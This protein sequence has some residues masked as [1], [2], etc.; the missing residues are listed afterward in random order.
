MLVNKTATQEFKDEVVAEVCGTIVATMGSDGKVIVCDR[1]DTPHPTKDG[2]TVA[3]AVRFSHPEKDLIASMIAECCIRTDRVCGDGTTTTAFLLRGFYQRFQHLI[4][5]RTK[6]KLNQYAQETLDVLSKLAQ[7]V[8]IDSELLRDVMMTTSNNDAR[9]VEKVLEIYRANPHLPDLELVESSSDQD[10]V[11]ERQGCTWTGGFYSPAFSKLGNGAPESFS[12][13][14]Y[15]PLL[16]SGNLTGF[17]TVEEIQ[18]FLDYTK[19]YVEQ[20]GTY[21]IICRSADDVAENTLNTLNARLN[22]QAYKLVR[23]RAAGSS[24]VSIINDIAQVLNVKMNAEL[25]SEAVQY[26][27]VQDYPTIHIT[28][29]V[30]SV[31]GHTAEHRKWLESAVTEVRRAI[32]ALDTDQRNSA[33]GKIVSGRLNILSGGSVKLYV[34]GL[35]DAEIKERID[36][37]ED[38]ARVCKSALTAGVLQGCGHSLQMA[39]QVLEAAHPEC[40]IAMAF[41]SVLRSQTPFLLGDEWKP[42]DDYM[43]LATGETAKEPGMLNIWDAALATRTALE[44]G[45]S[46]AIMLMDTHSLITNSRLNEVR[47]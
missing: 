25:I 2:V 41:C 19:E 24:G 31:V 9:I 38:V 16:V 46:M 12:G 6:Q 33:L 35:T 32:D 7:Q 20:G 29:S 5:Y 23:I 11:H 18:Q 30:M 43:N 27:V 21:V 17:N 39:A 28:A 40:D 36:R 3:K 1:N 42:G 26:N 15:R 44:A 37:F 34:G 4:G 47:F 45:L 14:G 22:R 13:E 8:E 10:E